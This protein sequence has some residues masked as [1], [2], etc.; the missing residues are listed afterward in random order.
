[1]TI[2][3]HHRPVLSFEEPEFGAALGKVLSASRPLQSEEMLRGREEQMAGI[4]QAFYAPGRHVL[5]HGFR[6]VG[7]SSLAQSAAFSIAEKSDPIIVA[8][9]PKSSFSSIIAD[10]FNEAGNNNLLLKRKSLKL[11]GVLQTPAFL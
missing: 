6:G 8:C 2:L 10:I 1:M 11:G 4:R 5:I 9:D 7:K 3:P